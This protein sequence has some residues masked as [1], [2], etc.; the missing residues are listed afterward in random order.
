MNWRSS[1]SKYKLH[2]IAAWLLLYTAWFYLRYEDYPGKA[3]L[4]TLIKVADLMIMVYITNYVLIPHLLYKKK[5]F[6]FAIIYISMIAGCSILKMSAEAA[7]FGTP[8]FFDLNTRFKARVY[9]N[10]IPHFLLVSTAAAFKLLSDYA[11]AQGRLGA[12]AKEKAETE[13]QFLKSQINPHFLFNSLNAIYFL[14]E[15]Q[16]TEARQ[17]LLQFS[18]LLRYQL[19]DCNAD[20]IAIEKELVYLTNFVKLQALRKDNHYEIEMNVDK[21]VAGFS[22]TPLLLIPFIENAFKHISH[23]AEKTNFVRIGLARQDNYFVMEVKN[24]KDN[25]MQTDSSGGIGLANVKRRLELIY[26][27]K[28]VLD[29]DSSE[30]IFSVKLQLITGK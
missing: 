21:N 5:H 16:N 7:V 23:H 17:T 27:G 12:M 11:A 14:I 15:K 22:I 9:D 1:I 20:N 8:G 10:I 24:S 6:L 2:H 4:I 28:H 25:S 3:W 29:I 26:P 19:Y 13:L 18:D 30:D